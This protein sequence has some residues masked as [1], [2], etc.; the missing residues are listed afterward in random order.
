[1]GRLRWILGLLGA[2]AIVFGGVSLIRHVPHPALVQVGVWLVAALIIH[3]GVVSPLVVGA[4]VGL[5][6]LPAR[7]RRYVQGAGIV[8]ACLVVIAAPMIY[9]RGRQ[10]PA[11]A[12]LVQDVAASLALL[13][14]L[15]VALTLA[16]YLIRL[17]RDH[18][19]R[20]RSSASQ[21]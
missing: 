6:R 2:C 15:V 20:A 14:G 7:A 16:A 8:I 4:G 3:D 10:P 12:V 21:D 13:V 1:M 5:S 18:S 11:K 9:L 19:V 17:L